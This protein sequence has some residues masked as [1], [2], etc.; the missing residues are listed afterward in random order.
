MNY[1]SLY[2]YNFSFININDYGFGIINEIIHNDREIKL[3]TKG[4]LN[5]IASINFELYYIIE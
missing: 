3:I 2:S 5:I 1:V 4:K